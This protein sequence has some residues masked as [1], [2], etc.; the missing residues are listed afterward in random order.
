MN[1][2]LPEY[3]WLHFLFSVQNIS[4]VSDITRYHRLKTSSQ[5]ITQ[6]QK[7]DARHHEAVNICDYFFSF[8]PVTPVTILIAQQS[9]W[10]RKYTS[11]RSME[12]FWWHN[13]L[14]GRKNI[15]RCFFDGVNV[16]AGILKKPAVIISNYTQHTQVVYWNHLNSFQKADPYW[17]WCFF[18]PFTNSS[19]QNKVFRLLFLGHV[20]TI[21]IQTSRASRLQ[22]FWTCAPG[23]T[24]LLMFC[25][26]RQQT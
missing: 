12:W 20:F 14:F 24:M 21:V 3:S 19:E 11:A 4:F 5:K 18:I 7:T 23:A 1:S 15:S 10:Q 22:L 26:K 13:N 16:L 9:V 2:S 6:Q 25:S 8:R 17:E